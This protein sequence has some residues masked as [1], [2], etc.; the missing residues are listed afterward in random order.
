MSVEDEQGKKILGAYP[1]RYRAP[2][3]IGEREREGSRGGLSFFSLCI[4]GGE[5]KG[6]GAKPCSELEH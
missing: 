1:K 2:G 3:K 4:L 5:E 6:V